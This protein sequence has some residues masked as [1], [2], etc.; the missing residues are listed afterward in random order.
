MSLKKWVTYLVYRLAYNGVVA[1]AR[2]VALKMGRR[3]RC[4]GKVSDSCRQ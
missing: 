2:R 3:L 4:S 1:A